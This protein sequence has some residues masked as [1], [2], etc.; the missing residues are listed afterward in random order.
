MGAWT[1]KCSNTIL[2]ILRVQASLHNE[3]VPAFSLERPIFF[4]RADTFFP[5]LPYPAIVAPL[6]RPARPLAGPPAG[7]APWRDPDAPRR[8]DAGGGARQRRPNRSR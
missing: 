4:S 3:A 2:E 5:C 1:G 7:D 6:R 8:R